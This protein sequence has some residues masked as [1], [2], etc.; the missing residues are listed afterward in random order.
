MLNIIAAILVFGVIILIHEF[1]HFSLAKLNGIGVLEFSIGMGPRLWSFQKGE[2]RYSIKALPFGG[3]CMMLGE[4]ESSGDE[5]AFPNKSV[6]AR[7]SVIVAGPAF[8]FILAF[9]LA[10]III[11]VS[12]YWS[13]QI[14]SVEPGYPAAEAGLEAGDTITK[15]NGKKVVFYQ[16]V[17]MHLMAYPM[18]AGE[19]VTVQYTRP[20]EGSD[21]VEKGTAVLVPKYSE[22]EGRYLMGFSYVPEEQTVSSLPSALQYGFYELKYCITS[23]FD[24]FK[25]LFGGQVKVDEAVAGPVRIVTMIG[26]IVDESRDYGMMTVFL[27]LANMCMLLSASLGIMNLLPIPALDGGRL[28]FL[29]IELVRGK[30]VDQEKEAMVHM[31]GM[32]LLMFLMVLILFNDIHFLVKG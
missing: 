4:D 15:I 22:K 23:T 14:A 2:T 13:P 5:R 28:L 29:L 9:I 17:V 11:G 31:A 21:G 19:T 27:S 12:G 32:M 26:G 7:I 20:V 16:E 6:W 3:S 30:P 24:S 10:T 25:M 1:G 8:N 18:T